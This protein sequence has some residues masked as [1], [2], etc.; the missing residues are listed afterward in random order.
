MWPDEINQGAKINKYRKGLV[1]SSENTEGSFGD[2]IQSGVIRMKSDGQRSKKKTKKVSKSSKGVS[3]V[4]QEGESNKLCQM[5]L[6]ITV[7]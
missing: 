7:L 1:L 4:F 3:K 2:R 6:R 5:L